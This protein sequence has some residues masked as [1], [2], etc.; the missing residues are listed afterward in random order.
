M[1][2]PV[3][4]GGF[5]TGAPTGSGLGWNADSATR[6]VPVGYVGGWEAAHRYQQAADDL[7]IE[8]VAL[9]SDAASRSGATA[10][11]SNFV[12]VERLDELIDRCGVITLGH[13]CDEETYASLLHGAGPK[14]RPNPLTIRLTHDPLAARYHLQNGGYGVAEFE[15]V[16]SGDTDSVQRFAL[17]HGWPVRLTAARWGTA[18][19]DVHLLRPYSLLDQVWT[20][21]GQPWL[22]EACEPSASQLTVVIA[23]SPS[24]HHIVHPVVATAHYDTQPYRRL[25]IAESISDR[26]IA[27][28]KSIVDGLDTIGISTVK[29]LHSSDGRL[30]VDDFTHGPEVVP[31][32]GAPVGNSLYATHLRTILGWSSEPTSTTSP[33]WPNASSSVHPDA[34]PAPAK[35]LTVPAIDKSTLPS[36]HTTV[37]PERAP[38]RAF[39]YRS[40]PSNDCSPTG[41][42]PSGWLLPA[43]RASRPEWEATWQVG[44]NCR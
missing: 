23:R 4:S 18:S 32:F 28:A 17:Q 37:G 2:Q 41:P 38:H 19:P 5:P 15:E 44:P 22:L 33:N 6:T 13:G 35:G 21:R 14:L 12:A 3:N 42:M 43:C 31:P 10:E 1:V 29:F 16:D 11:T 24:G 20:D 8:M 9:I 34:S 25:P 7:D 36:R 27:T 40:V 30:L 39:L 26:A